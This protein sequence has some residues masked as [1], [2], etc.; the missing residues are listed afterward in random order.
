MRASPFR[1]LAASAAAA[2]AIVAAVPTRATTMGEPAN[3]AG[4]VRN[5]SVIVSGT[6]TSVRTAR[7]GQMNHVE[8]T[9]QVART[10]RGEVG[11]TFTFRQIGLPAPEGMGQGRIYLG[12]VAGLPQYR[13]GEQVLLFLGPESSAGFRTTV[14]LGQGTFRYTAGNVQNETGNRGLFTALPM[15]KAHLSVAESV[16]VDT[17]KGFVAA[18]SF[19]GLVERAVDENWWGAPSVPPAHGPGVGDGVSLD[20]PAKKGGR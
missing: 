19:V 6:V 18:D 2:V 15:A 3:L 14:G 7:T 11:S 4:L 16:M 8:V 5:A 13:E 20:R 9:L 1:R 12:G 10:L 17:T